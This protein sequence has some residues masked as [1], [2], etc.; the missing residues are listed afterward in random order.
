MLGERRFLF[1]LFPPYEVCQYI[2]D[3]LLSFVRPLPSARRHSYI[4]FISNDRSFDAPSLG[5]RRAR[6]IPPSAARRESAKYFDPRS[7][8]TG[9]AEVQLVGFFF[10]PSF[11]SFFLSVFLSF[12]TPKKRRP[13]AR[14]EDLDALGAARHRGGAHREKSEGRGRVVER[15]GGKRGWKGSEADETLANRDWEVSKKRTTTRA[16]RDALLSGLDPFF[17]CIQTKVRNSERCLLLGEAPRWNGRRR[18]EER[19]RLCLGRRKKRYTFRRRQT[20]NFRTCLR[21]RSSRWKET[22]E[23]KICRSG[24]CSEASSS[25]PFSLSLSLSFVLSS[26]FPI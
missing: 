22:A 14:V 8:S 21:R 23:C 7:S 9:M 6:R 20:A 17:N 19:H 24:S 5:T 12:F 1:P 13:S 15:N 2:D 16:A 25:F 26:A 10:P 3:Q 18:E 4:A 11:L